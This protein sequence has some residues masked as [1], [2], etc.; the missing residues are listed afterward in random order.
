MRR[1]LN[2]ETEEQRIERFEKDARRRS[3]VAA[4]K[5]EDIDAMVKRSIKFHGP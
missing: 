5:D 2:P 3:E 1:K 4:A